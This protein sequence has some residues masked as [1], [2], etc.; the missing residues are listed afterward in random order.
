MTLAHAQDRVA[1]VIGNSNYDTVSP[2][3]N[4]VRD[5]ELIAQTLQSI[6]FEVTLLIDATQSD[7]NR[8]LSQFGRSLREKGP[9]TTGLFYY[10]GHGVQSFGNNYLLPVDV[11]LGDAADLDLESVEAQSVLR[12][13]ASARNRTNFVILDACRNNPFADIPEF[14][15]PGLAEMKAPTGTFLSY[16]TAPGAV[17]LDG[18]GQNSPF[19]QALVQEMVK[20]GLAVEQMFKQVRVS[21]LEKTAGQQTPWDTSSLTSDFRFVDAPTEDPEALAARQLWNS[22]QAT[23]D[24]VQIMLFLRGYPNSVHVNDARE[25]LATVIEEELTSP[26]PQAPAA[27]TA[28]PSDQEQQ[29]FEAAQANPTIAAYQG[30]LDAFPNGTFAEFAK[31]EITAL[32]TNTGTDPVGDGVTEPAPEVEIAAIQERAA[33]PTVV[34]F[35]GPLQ[36]PGSPIDGFAISDL[37][38]LS[39]QFPPIPDLPEALW[40]NA[41]CASCHEWNRERLCEQSNNYL[42]LSGQKSLEKAHPFDG[43]L[44][45]N[46]RQWAAGGCQ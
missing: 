2:L 32:A 29:M 38:D 8:A 21:V 45:R 25:L 9:D 46:L 18:T 36:A 23:R 16:A 20:P 10:A 43:A 4:P 19:T 40:A 14:N 24:P 35:N 6:D 12:Q 22:V 33:A 3:D 44:K 11:S 37:F 26:E 1:L 39:P 42:T 13:M 41:T 27:V 7:M 15:D 31:Q 28:G 34:T 5:A 30:Y 17:A